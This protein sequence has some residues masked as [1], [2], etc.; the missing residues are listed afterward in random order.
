ML[1][2][3]FEFAPAYSKKWT[4]RKSY[5]IAF[6][7]LF[8]FVWTGFHSFPETDHF[9]QSLKHAL[10]KKCKKK[11]ICNS[12][13]LSIILIVIAYLQP[14]T[15]TESRSKQP[16]HFYIFLSFSCLIR[17]NKILR[18]R[19]LRSDARVF[20]L[21]RRSLKKF[22]EYRPMASARFIN[23]FNKVRYF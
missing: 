23:T 19:C 1:V 3:K 17:I 11:I 10:V 7:I 4:T 6:S 18:R 8:H 16:A 13:Y 9:Q 14:V 22:N 12:T 2:S 5:L 15:K 21:K 20:A